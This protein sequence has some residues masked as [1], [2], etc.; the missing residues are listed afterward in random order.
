MQIL[1]FSNLILYVKKGNLFCMNIKIAEFFF[2]FKLSFLENTFI[3]L[4]ITHII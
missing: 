3:N 4:A 1:C 2:N